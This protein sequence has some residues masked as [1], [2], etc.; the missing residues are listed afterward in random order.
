LARDRR[1]N[2]SGGRVGA[3]RHGR[4]RPAVSASG[5]VGAVDTAAVIILNGNGGFDPVRTP[6]EFPDRH[7]VAAYLRY[8]RNPATFEFDDVAP[9][10]KTMDR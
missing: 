1:A 5:F 2:S 10:Y 9:Y 6:K 8:L 7:A 4:L 3:N